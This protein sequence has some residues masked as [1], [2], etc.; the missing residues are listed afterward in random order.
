MESIQGIKFF[1]TEDACI[2][3]YEKESFCSKVYYVAMTALNEIKYLFEKVWNALT[4]AKDSMEIYSEMKPAGRAKNKLIVCLHG[5]NNRPGHFT[6]M[7]YELNQSDMSQTALFIPKIKEKGHAQLDEMVDPIVEEI[8]HWARFGPSMGCDKE[9]VLV[10]I[11]N[12]GRIAKAIE[13]KLALEKKF[14]AVNKLRFVSIVGATKGSSMASLA[15]RLGLSCLMKPAISK[16]MPFECERMKKLDQEHRDGVALTSDIDRKYVFFA[17][18]YDL[19]VP[20]RKST[21]PSLNGID[22]RYA[23]LPGHGHESI[24]KA[25]SRCAASMI[26][27]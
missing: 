9:L 24:V 8:E 4:C 23:L 20:D 11:S 14:Y 19:M 26:A 6:H 16:E 27:S 7:A 22:A 17:S 3:H 10:G 21:L 25:V 2:K 13:A 1:S 5:L 12:G 15:N 18:P